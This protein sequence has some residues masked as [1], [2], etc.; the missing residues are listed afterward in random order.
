M[1]RKGSRGYLSVLYFHNPFY[2]ISTC[3]FVYGLKLL[4]RSGNTNVFFE[5]G[6]VAYMEPW[7]L[8]AGLAGVTIL[9][10]VTAI[11][12]VR[13]GKVWEDARSLVLIV[14]LMILAISVSFDELINVLS[15][16]D[17]SRRH[18]FT[19]F[20]VS[21]VFAIAVTE[22][23]LR[24]LQVRLTAAYRL[25]LFGF[26]LLFFLWPL[27]LLTEVTGFTAEQ[28]RWLIIGFPCVA[29]IL[30]MSLVPAIQQGSAAVKDNGTPWSWPL[31]PWTPFVF[32]ALAVCFRSY[33]LTMSF[34]PIIASGH[35]WDT[36][37]GVYQLV[38][39]LLAILFLLVQ[40]GLKENLPRLTSGVLIAAPLLLVLAHPWMVPWRGLAVYSRFTATVVAEF[41][42]PVFL[43]LIGLTALYGW[44]WAKGVR[45][46][47]LGF[48]GMLL[49]CTIVGP[50]AFGSS[51]S[52]W[53]F[54]ATFIWPA[55]VL[56]ILNVAIG[57]RRASS[58]RVAVG[59]VLAAGVG[60]MSVQ[61]HPD[62]AAW[63]TFVAIHLAFVLLLCLSRVFN[64]SF[65]RLCR[66]IGPLVLFCITMTG[67]YQL[68][69]RQPLHVW[70]AVYPVVMIVA[71]FVLGRLCR[72]A[73][74]TAVAYTEGAI[75]GIIS[76]F[77]GTY[78]FLTAKLVAGLKQ[79]VLAVVCFIGGVFIS[80]L[81]AGLGRRI[82]LFFIKRKRQT[83]S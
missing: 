51:G 20:W 82:R 60:S 56:G 25:P 1:A 6:S 57:V 70:F 54:S 61:G 14:L 65:A 72:D 78:L 44:A 27:G 66:E 38:P 43:T 34:D 77:Y 11:L 37:F 36:I 50:R 19:M 79:I 16:R 31:F 39:F 48:S 47:E 59:L 53:S 45:I 63:R 3:L 73:D 15:D 55:L 83:T 71:A 74:Y 64:D 12:I 24:G 9:M 42:S 5:S 69:Q 7:G 2:L 4:F 17:N 30:T 80:I 18:L 41:A 68:A 76:A 35:Y 29:A 75:L 23:L 52:S 8:M 58:F 46:A 67:C 28:T 22:L 62:V 32:I 49:L 13:F 40:I 10:C 33:S 21:L 81:K 26:M